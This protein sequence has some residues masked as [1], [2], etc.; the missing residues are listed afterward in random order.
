[1]MGKILYGLGFVLV[2]PFG[3]LVWESQL[4]KT[5]TGLPLLQS[6]L[7]GS[8][9][10]ASGFILM[11]LGWRA[12]AKFGE[13]LP[14]N[15]FPPEKLV[16]VDIYS[17]ISHP[18][19]TGFA[20]LTFGHALFAGSVAGVWI[21]TPFV[22]V[23]SFALVFGYERIDMEKRFGK[24]TWTSAIGLPPA[25]DKAPKGSN[26]L[27]VF[28]LVFL[29]WLIGYEAF[30][31]IG[32]FPDAFDTYLRFE[33]ALPVVEWTEVLYAFTYVF[34]ILAPL[35][36][37]SQKDLRNFMI[38][39]LWAMAIGFLCFLLLPFQATPRPFEPMGPIGQLLRLDRSLDG[40]AGAFPAFHALWALLSAWLFARTFGKAPL[41]YGFAGLISLS[42]ITTGMHSLLDILGSIMVY[43]IVLNSKRIWGEMLLLTQWFANSWREWRLGPVRII[44]HGFYVGIGAFLGVLLAEN[45]AGSENLG[46]VLIVSFS[47]LIGA[48]IWGQAL[49]GSSKL[50]R[51]FGFYGGLFGGITGVFIAIFSGYDGWL[52]AGA[53][54]VAGPLAQ[55]IGRLRCLVQ[56]CC[57][58]RECSPKCGI[59]VSH[60]RSRVLYLAKLGN[61]SIYPTQLYSLLFNFALG[62]VL[63]RLWSLSCPIPLLIGGYLVLG[64]IGRFVEESYRGEPQTLKSGG[65]AIYQWLALAVILAGAMIMTIQG[66]PGI[67]DL[68]FLP[69]SPLYAGLFGVIV[70]MAMGVDFPESGKRFS[71]L[72]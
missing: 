15:A 46:G 56:G 39:G 25:E 72:T 45:L 41:W 19:Y 28:V 48:G 67:E 9:L 31:L 22:V 21:I 53:F 36:A 17:I 63:W 47:S 12:L 59:I 37:R 55:A 29:P 26:R 62:A 20:M 23:C 6:S 54:A 18:I 35:F 65:L 52:I 33:K 32:P 70:A 34:V 10:M 16:T 64:G 11:V 49:E 27:S 30:I 4:D 50:S 61:R 24:V 14:M 38:M 5:L 71:R 68:S 1:M 60:K 8:T 51:P 58:G 69:W 13:G 57:H 3:L 43:T 2:L 66:K 7:L 42:C 40:A 44:N